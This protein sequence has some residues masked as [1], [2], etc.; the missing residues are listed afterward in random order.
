LI[1]CGVAVAAGADITA[2]G[3]NL[4]AAAILICLKTNL[5][6]GPCGDIGIPS[7]ISGGIGVVAGEIRIPGAGDAIVVV[8][9][10]QTPAAQCAGTVVRDGDGTG[11]AVGP[12]VGDAVTAI[13][14]CCSR[15]HGGSEQK[16]NSPCKSPGFFKIYHCYSPALSCWSYHSFLFT[17]RWNND[18]DCGVI[19]VNA[20]TDAVSVPACRTEKT[21]FLIHMLTCIRGYL[22]DLRQS[23]A[24]Q[25]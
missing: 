3:R 7:Q 16:G 24:V 9:P 4:S 2:Q 10:A 20:G 15:L 18:R 25:V 11:V 5:Y 19:F 1:R 14:L 21:R 22:A 17:L 13:S 23:H 8:T 6:A 12:F